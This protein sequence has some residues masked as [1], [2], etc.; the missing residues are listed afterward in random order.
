MRLLCAFSGIMGTISMFFY[1]HSDARSPSIV[2]YQAAYMKSTSEYDAAS[3][4]SVH[5]FCLL[6]VQDLRMPRAQGFTLSD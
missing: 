1:L 4:Q 5:V 6:E 2:W 3:R